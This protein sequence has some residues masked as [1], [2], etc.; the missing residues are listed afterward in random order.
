MELPRAVRVS[1]P[2]RCWLFQCRICVT[3]SDAN[4]HMPHLRLTRRAI[5]SR[6]GRICCIGACEWMV[7]WSTRAAGAPSGSWRPMISGPCPHARH[8]SIFKTDPFGNRSTAPV[9]RHNPC[10][11]PGSPQLSRAHQAA[12]T[13]EHDNDDRKF[14]KGLS[15]TAEDQAELSPRSR[16]MTLARRRAAPK[17]RSSRFGVPDP[18]PPLANTKLRRCS[19]D[20]RVAA[21]HYRR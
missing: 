15:R 1:N 7:F 12:T 4:R 16:P 18:R 17:V 14:T 8:V 20:G 13:Q 21:P 3:R 10:W 19:R 5:R 11:S 2:S 9:R 6:F